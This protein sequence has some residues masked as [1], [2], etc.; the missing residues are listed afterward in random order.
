MLPLAS[1]AF[2]HVFM[3]GGVHHVNDR[4]KLFSEVA[5]ILKPGGKFVYREPVSDFW[6]WRS[7]RNIIYKIAPALD[8]ETERPLRYPE[9]VPILSAV[10]LT[11]E[12]WKTYGFLGFCI[13][14]NSDVLVFNRLFR[15]VPG[16][17]T[18]V[19]NATRMDEFMLSLPGFAGCGLQVVG[20]AVKTEA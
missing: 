4:T 20:R 11:T 10:G 13:F 17:R 7:L 19:R 3:L 9:T 16:I 5:R 15:F 2:D 6:L 14:M 18:I 12:L 1:Q 8:H